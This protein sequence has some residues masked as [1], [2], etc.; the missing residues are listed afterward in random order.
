M[1]PFSQRVNRSLKGLEGVHSPLAAFQHVIWTLE[2]EK[3]TYEK[4]IWD[5]RNTGKKYS[6]LRAEYH[7]LV[8]DITIV[9][10]LFNIMKGDPLPERAK[11]KVVTPPKD[12]Y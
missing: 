6:K 1:E 8:E 5:R 10:S 3:E 12:G 2:R 9:Q 4:E 7:R 11:P